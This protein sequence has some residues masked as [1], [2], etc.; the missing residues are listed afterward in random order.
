MKKIFILFLFSIN[1]YA[2][3]QYYPDKIWEEKSPES[4]G[5]NSK[6]TK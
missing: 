1:V 2:Q 4:L 6:K 3:D 5:I